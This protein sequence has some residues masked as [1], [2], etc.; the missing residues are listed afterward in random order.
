[1]KMGNCT[2]RLIKFEDYEK[3]DE[4]WELY[5][6]ADENWRLC[7]MTDEIWEDW[8]K[9]ERLMKIENYMKRLMKFGETDENWRLYE[10]TN[11]NWEL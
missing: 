5:E 11:E 1:M 9:L 3:A 6:E 8:W 7:E 4:I 2:K 10:K